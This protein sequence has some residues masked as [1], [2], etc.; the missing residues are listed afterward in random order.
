MS[1]DELEGLDKVS[2]DL[3]ITNMIK[4]VSRI[5]HDS[6]PLRELVRIEDF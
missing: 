1:D 3:K 5:A 4:Y 2:K 6:W